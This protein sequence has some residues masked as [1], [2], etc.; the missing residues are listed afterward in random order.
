[1]PIPTRAWAWTAVLA[2]SVALLLSPFFAAAYLA[3]EDGAGDP[4]LLPWDEAFRDAGGAAFT[5]GDPDE[6]YATYGKLAWTL[7]LGIL[8]GAVVIHAGQA[9]RAGRAEK[10]GFWMLAAGGALTTLG[11]LVFFF[12]A[13]SDA[14]FFA[15][16]VPGQLLMIIGCLV[17]GIGTLRAPVA[18]RG[19][20]WLLTVGGPLQPVLSAVLGHNPLAF[21][22]VL[23]ACV[24]AGVRV[25]RQP[26]PA[27]A[28]GH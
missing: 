2:S 9:A 4:P 12:I 15:L 6:L 23:V 25:L 1:M 24:W 27:S 16:L 10:V 7:G 20:A 13:L 22:P 3:T 28:M 5:F 19:I 11:A 17:F 14:T 8:A 26:A 21:A 18:P